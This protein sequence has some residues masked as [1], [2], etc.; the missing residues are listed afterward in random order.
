MRSEVEVLTWSLGF[1]HATFELARAPTAR[2]AHLAPSQT[3]CERGLRRHQW[4]KIRH[5][6]PPLVIAVTTPPHYP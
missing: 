1:R 3:A 6:C 5:F 2:P 4:W